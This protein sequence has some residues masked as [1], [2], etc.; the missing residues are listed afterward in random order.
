MWLVNPGNW[1]GRAIL[2]LLGHFE[3][4]SYN[5]RSLH[6]VQVMVD[7]FV[8]LGSWGLGLITYIVLG[9]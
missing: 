8:L 6:L 9:H 1:A 3:S 2:V 5:K 7:G 4:V